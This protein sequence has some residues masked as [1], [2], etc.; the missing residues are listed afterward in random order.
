MLLLKVLSVCSFLNLNS[1]CLIVWLFVTWSNICACGKTKLLKLF[2]CIRCFD[3]NRTF[4]SSNCCEI[5]TFL[6]WQRC[7]LFLKKKKR[8]KPGSSLWSEV[9]MPSKFC[10]FNPNSA[11]SVWERS[12]P[13]SHQSCGK[14]ISE[15]LN[16]WRR[17]LCG[18]LTRQQH[19]PINH[20]MFLKYSSHQSSRYHQRLNLM[21]NI[22]DQFSELIWVK[23]FMEEMEE[24]G[25]KGKFRQ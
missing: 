18:F 1:V 7:S 8:L 4:Y 12:L 19:L 22:S 20:C 15:N 13:S 11:S 21:S 9:M 14:Y 17:N 10:T 6:H 24:V 2:L 5:V 3:F 23:F 16:D 25:G